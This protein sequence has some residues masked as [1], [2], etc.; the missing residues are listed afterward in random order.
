MHGPHGTDIEKKTGKQW[1]RIVE[2]RDAELDG[3][4]RV[5]GDLR[6]NG[7]KVYL[8]VNTHYEGCAPL[9]IQRIRECDRRS[10]STPKWP[11]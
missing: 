7:V 2:P 5:A 1:N 4:A 8:N 6:G 11:V 10:S 3:I 9:T